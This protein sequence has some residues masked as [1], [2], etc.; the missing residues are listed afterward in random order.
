MKEKDFVTKQ[1][2]D[3]G[4]L[5]IGV[6][7]DDGSLNKYF[8]L[9]D[10]GWKEEEDIAKIQEDRPGITAGKFVTEIMARLI[11]TW[12]P[13]NFDNMETVERIVRLNQSFFA[14]VMFAYVCLRIKSLGNKI[15]LDITCPG[16]REKIKWEGDLNT[17][18]VMTSDFDK[19]EDLISRYEFESPIKLGEFNVAWIA[20]RPWLW[21]VIYNLPGGEAATAHVIRKA[22][23][24]DAVVSGEGFD[25]EAV[26][27]TEDRL[28][29]LRKIDIERIAKIIDGGQ[30]GTDLRTP[31]VCPS[32]KHRWTAF[33]D[34]SYEVF[35]GQSSL[36]IP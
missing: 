19:F 2:S 33:A 15:A 36:S 17:L 3:V 29:T 20:H 25:D 7:Q 1:L 30:G 4:G 18:E 5:P 24:L 28:M 13:Y 22:V 35:F 12:G 9:H 10:W 14:D 6:R 11:K 31:M 27:M 32:C 8:S 21:H 34:W 16:C 23:F 26:V